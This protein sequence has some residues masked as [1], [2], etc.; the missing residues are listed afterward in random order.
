MIFSGE[1]LS[2]NDGNFII[3]KYLYVNFILKKTEICYYL[4][5]VLFDFLVMFVYPFLFFKIN[6]AEAEILNKSLDAK[7]SP[8]ELKR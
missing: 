4:E 7:E 5:S 8:S 1:Y 2:E 3:V 6:F